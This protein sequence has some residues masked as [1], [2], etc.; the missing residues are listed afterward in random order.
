MLG[1]NGVFSFLQLKPNG[2]LVGIGS[3]RGAVN[4]ILANFRQE[5]LFLREW[6]NLRSGAAL[7]RLVG[8]FLLQIDIKPVDGGIQGVDVG[9][10]SRDGALI[11]LPA[12]EKIVEFFVD[13]AEA[14]S[15]VLLQRLLRLITKVGLYKG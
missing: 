12:L 9:F 10:N 13:V 8:D 3:V 1:I 2:Q 15:D 5:I 14:A 6:C 11:D 7:A 4:E